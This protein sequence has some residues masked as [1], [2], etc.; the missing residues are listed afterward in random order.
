MIYNFEWDPNKAATNLEK[1]TISFEE[2]ATVFRD[3]KALTIFDPDHSETEERWLT[4]GIS[5]NSKLLVVSHAFQKADQKTATI[6]II[7]SRKATKTE[8]KQY[9]D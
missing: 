7:S 6:R 3:P 4:I 9:G 2:A 8:S 5:K 1:H